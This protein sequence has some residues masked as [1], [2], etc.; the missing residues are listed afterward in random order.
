MT[1]TL[2]IFLFLSIGLFGLGAFG[3]LIRRHALLMLMSVELMLNA[4]NVAFVT[5]ARRWGGAEADAAQ[6]FVL[7]IMGV[8]AAEAAIGIAIVVSIFRAR[9]H[10]NVDESSELRG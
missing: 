7:M 1:P 9:G 5:F 10:V 3:V 2:D 4:V 8:A 6:I